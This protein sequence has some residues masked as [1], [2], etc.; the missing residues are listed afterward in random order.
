MLTRV[1]QQRVFVEQQV[2]ERATTLKGEAQETYSAVHLGAHL[3][4]GPRS[5]GAVLMCKP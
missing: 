4:A 2:I 5:Q 1:G 3:L